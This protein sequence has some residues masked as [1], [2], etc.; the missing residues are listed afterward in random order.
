MQSLLILICVFTVFQMYGQYTKDLGE[1]AKQ[2]AERIK[3][4]TRKEYPGRFKTYVP[5]KLE[6]CVRKCSVIHS[7]CNAAS[8]C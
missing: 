2:E 6:C 4:L 5:G 7:V 3:G 1:F 8:I